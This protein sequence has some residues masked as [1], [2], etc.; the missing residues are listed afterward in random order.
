MSESLW[1][2]SSWVDV[3]LACLKDLKGLVMVSL[4][5]KQEGHAQAQL[6][7]LCSSPTLFRYFAQEIFCG[8]LALTSTYVTLARPL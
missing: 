7:G 2:A 4:F 3:Y 5:P 6:M 8:Q 1:F